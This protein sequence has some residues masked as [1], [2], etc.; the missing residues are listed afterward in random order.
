ME[1]TLYV[2]VEPYKYRCLI[3]DRIYGSGGL[4]GHAKM[5]LRAGHA[6]QRAG[7]RRSAA[8]RYVLNSAGLA[9]VK[10]K[11]AEGSGAAHDLKDALD[12]LRGMVLTVE[13]LG[14]GNAEPAR[15]N[16]YGCVER[17]LALKKARDLLAR[18]GRI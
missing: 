2:Y 1:T 9:L 15:R 4:V 14:D 11:Q 18:L 13:A 5:H 12:A 16:G 7:Y 17:G 6:S 10:P 8:G 3:C